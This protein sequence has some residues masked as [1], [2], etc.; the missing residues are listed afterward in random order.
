MDTS[1]VKAEISAQSELLGEIPIN[2]VLVSEIDRHI[3]DTEQ[4]L[5]DRLVHIGAKV[6]IQHFLPMTK[7]N[8]YASVVNEEIW[9]NLYFQKNWYRQSSWYE[10]ISF[11]KT[12]K[13]YGIFYTFGEVFFDLGVCE[14]MGV[15]WYVKVLEDKRETFRVTGAPIEIKLKAFKQLRKLLNEIIAQTANF[16]FSELN[17]GSREQ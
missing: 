16:D 14:D 4:Q 8:L 17:G 2:Q 11:E 1:A 15:D 12:A 9:N 6:I 3:K 10:E 5:N 13:G 7:K